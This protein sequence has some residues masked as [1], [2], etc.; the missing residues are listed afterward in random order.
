[1]F[2]RV[3]LICLL[4][5]AA[6]V[7]SVYGQ[8]VGEEQELNNLKSELSQIKAQLALL[9]PLMLQFE[10]INRRIK[11][12]EQQQK[13]HTK[14]ASSSASPPR[15]T[16]LPKSEEQQLSHQTRGL[17]REAKIYAT[18]RPTLGYIDENNESQWDVRDALSHAGFKSTVEFTD[19]WQGILH[20]EWGI[21][22]SNNGDFGK[23]R[24]V[25]VALYSPYGTVG[26][27]KQRPA[28]YLFIAEYVD[29]F[30]HGN[31]PF[32]YDPESLFFVDNLLSYQISKGH[33]TWM[34][35]SQF[36]G[37]EGD[38]NSDLINGGVSYDKDNL[39]IAIT[40]TKISEYEG[41]RELDDNEILGG[42]FAYTFD[43]GLYFALGYQDKKYSRDLIHDKQGHT[44]DMSMAYPFG[45][46]YKVKAGYF[47]FDDGHSANKTHKFH[48]ANLTFEWLPVENLRLHVE[49][50]HRDFEY[51]ADF[52]S[53]SIGFRYDYAEVWR[54]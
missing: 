16:P 38:N 2:M 49:F 42:S 14:M 33:F 25:Y 24:Q 10:A 47:D 19:N 7:F 13:N 40:Y 53:L 45:K 21:D 39:H 41:E 36:D 17:E 48:G 11:V 35:V 54:Y 26:I 32:A 31:S 22:L 6:N 27:G 1:M 3:K 51:L 28:Q 37:A 5:T 23:A 12:L 9:E 18:L 52:N 15:E 4:F 46:Y 8:E 30:N 20:G 50:L 29:I 44:F 43:S 34:L